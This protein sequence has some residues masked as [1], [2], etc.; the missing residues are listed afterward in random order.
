VGARVKGVAD[1]RGDLLEVLAGIAA[2]S[3]RGVGH[4]QA[5]FRAQSWGEVAREGR[6]QD[7]SGE[8]A[9]QETT[10]TAALRFG[11]CHVPHPRSMIR[12]R[13]SHSAQGRTRFRET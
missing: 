7:A 6:S 10:S 1:A 12:R 13:L 5:E 8:D 3:S 11:V 4:L 2:K 9:D